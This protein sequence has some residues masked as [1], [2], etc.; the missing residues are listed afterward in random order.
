MENKSMNNTEN[1]DLPIKQEFLPFNNKTNSKSP[2]KKKKTPHLW[3]LIVLFIIFLIM[4]TYSTIKILAWNEE[5]KKTNQTIKQVD[6][7]TNVEE[8]QDTQETELIN[9]PENLESDYWYY[10]K[11]PLIQVNFEELK[12]KNNDTIGWIQVNSTNINYPIVQTENNNFYLTHSYDKTENEAGWVFMDFRN[13]PDFSSKNTIIY[14][15]SR[16]N[17]TM[18]GSLS[19][20][21]KKSWYQNKDNHIIK[22]STPQENSLWQIFSVYKIEEET[23]YI[24]T[25]FQDDNTYLDFLTTLK[26]RSKYEFDTNLNETDHILTL[27]TCYSDTERTVVHAK[28]IKKS[29]RTS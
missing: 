3:I 25:D 6:K 19:K 24:T 13:I 22:I 23:Y 2:K 4:I 27:S 18:F 28:M 14:A 29:N 16:L 5:N 1:Y 10:I 9:E 7:I 26:S 12:K 11:F 21:L 8:I 15:H 20:V 17:K